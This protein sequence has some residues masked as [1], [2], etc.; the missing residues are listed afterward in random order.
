[1][2]I[3]LFNTKAK[4]P[5][6]HRPFTLQYAEQIQHY[7]VADMSYAQLTITKCSTQPN[8]C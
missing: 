7:T 4:G 5:K 2:F 6:G 3:Y 8:L 1:M